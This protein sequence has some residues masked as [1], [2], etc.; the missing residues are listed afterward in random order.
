[1]NL[2]PEYPWSKIIRIIVWI[3]S[4]NLRLHVLDTRVKRGSEL[5]TDHHLLVSLIRKWRKTLDRPGKPEQ[6]VQVN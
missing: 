6:V 2:V 3:V 4:S 1:M 5:S